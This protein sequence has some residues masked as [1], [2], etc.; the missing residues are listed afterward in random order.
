MMGLFLSLPAW[1][2]EAV[3]LQCGSEGALP[4][5]GPWAVGRDL[6]RCR[7]TAFPA[8]QLPKDRSKPPCPTGTLSTGVP[9]KAKHVFRMRFPL[10][11]ADR[12]CRG[13]P[14]GK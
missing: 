12:S 1:S 4:D 5:C 10:I 14:T 3:L 8:A 6:S 13:P 11:V 7:Y 9:L 2:E